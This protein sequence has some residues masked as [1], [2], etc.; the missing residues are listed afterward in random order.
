VEPKTSP[1]PTFFLPLPEGGGGSKEE[2]IYPP[3]Y[4][5]WKVSF[6]LERRGLTP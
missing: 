5:S 4:S 6:S 3:P 1:S 2:F